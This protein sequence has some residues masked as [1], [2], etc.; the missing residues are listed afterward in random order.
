MIIDPLSSNKQGNDIGIQYRT[1]IYYAANDQLNIIKDFCEKKEKEIGNKLAVEILPI[2]NLWT[3][4]K[5]I[6]LIIL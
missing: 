2:K 3:L 4:K 1:G 6:L 5:Y